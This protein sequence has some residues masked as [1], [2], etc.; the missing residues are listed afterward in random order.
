MAQ[1]K[2]AK[3]GKRLVWRITPSAPL[4]EFVDPDASPAPATPPLPA[5]EVETRG[6]WMMSSFDLLHGTDIQ[7]GPDTVPDELFDELFAPPT[8][9]KRPG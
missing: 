7:E 9:P 4:G 8:A 1:G 6:G 2:N 3:P 5:P